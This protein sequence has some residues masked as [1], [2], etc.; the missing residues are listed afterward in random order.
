[1]KEYFQNIIFQTM[2][3]KAR[4][5]TN[6]DESFPSINVLLW[7]FLTAKPAGGNFEE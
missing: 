4:M 3:V 6:V 7:R 1:M 5:A 2:R